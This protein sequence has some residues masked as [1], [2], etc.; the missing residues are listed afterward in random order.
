M[1]QETTENIKPKKS[2]Q[3]K[4]NIKQKK[5][6][7]IPKTPPLPPKKEDTKILFKRDDRKRG[8]DL[9]GQ[10]TLDF[11]ILKDNKKIFTAKRN[12]I[13]TEFE[14]FCKDIMEKREDEFKE[15]RD[16]CIENLPEKDTKSMK[17][18]DIVLHIIESGK[19]DVDSAIEKLTNNQRNQIT[20]REKFYSAITHKHLRTDQN[21]LEVLWYWTKP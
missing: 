8:F 20:E 10:K 18:Q 5:E 12:E 1:S 3:K 2:K 11:S 19:S 13:N 21:F 15:D 4:K 16:E 14:A 6:D 7:E 9:Y 17:E